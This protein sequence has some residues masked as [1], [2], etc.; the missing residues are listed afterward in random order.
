[1]ATASEVSE[2]GGGHERDTLPPTGKGKRG[3]SADIMASLEAR[4]QRVEFAMADNRDK[5]EDMDQRIDGLEGGNEEFHREMQGIL[6][7]LAESWKAQMDALKDSLQAEIAAIKEEIKEVKGDWS[8]CK[9]AVTQG[10]ISSSHSPKVD[11]PRPKSYNGSRNARELDNFLWD[12]DQYFEATGIDEENKKIK[13]GPSLSLECGHAMVEAA[14]CGYGTPSTRRHRARPIYGVAQ[15]V[16]LH[17]GDWCGQVDFTVVPMDDYPIVL[18]MEFLDGVRA[19][20]I[21]FAETMCIM[22]ERSACMVPLARETLSKSKTLSA[23][24]LSKEDHSIGLETKAK[25]PA[26]ILTKSQGASKLAKGWHADKAKAANRVKECTSKNRQVESRNSKP[27]DS[28]E[29]LWGRNNSCHGT[30]RRATSTPRENPYGNSWTR[31]P[32]FERL[33]RGRRQIGWGRMLQAQQNPPKWPNIIAH[34]EGQVAWKS[35]ECSR[36]LMGL[37]KTWRRI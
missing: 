1:M 27:K 7:S 31:S 18:G 28:K 12:L 36:S 29:I 34:E 23:M 11:I 33:R 19:F 13:N 2:H 16:R 14:T 30:S 10:T 37:P 8:L 6:N 9:M 24:Q 32:N 26:A 22:G 4:L 17:I 15:D 3:K 20:P 25:I 5:V 35:L 21:P